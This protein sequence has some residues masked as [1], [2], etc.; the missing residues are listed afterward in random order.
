MSDFIVTVKFKP[1][2]FDAEGEATLEALK[3]LKFDVSAVESRKS[4]L[5]KTKGSRENVEEM[6]KK[7]LA[8]PVI[9]EYSIQEA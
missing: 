1:G 8:N 2:V 9:Q 6:C 5:I 3:S 7:L 4:Y